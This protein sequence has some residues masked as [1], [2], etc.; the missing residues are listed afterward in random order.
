M[1][2]PIS[3]SRSEEALQPEI[4]ETAVNFIVPAVKRIE[5]NPGD[6]AQ[7]ANI[8]LQLGAELK[9]SGCAESGII[10]VSIVRAGGNPVLVR[11]SAEYLGAGQRP[12]EPLAPGSLIPVRISLNDPGRDAYGYEVDVCIMTRTQGLQCQQEREPFRP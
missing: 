12:A 3:P 4:Q 7:L 5:F 9:S 11:Q 8:I 6:N 2:S 10:L 1:P